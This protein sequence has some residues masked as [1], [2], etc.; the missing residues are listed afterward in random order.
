M[1][2]LWGERWSV[3]LARVFLLIVIAGF[4]AAHV[5]AEIIT[6][7]E[8]IFVPDAVRV[9]YC[10]K[11]VEFIDTAR[12]CEPSVGTAS[13][14]H[15]LYNQFFS[16]EFDETNKIKIRFTAG[17]NEVSVKVGLDRDYPYHTSDVFAKIDAYSSDTPGTGLVT[18]SSLNL[19]TTTTPI[20]KE[21]KVVSAAD[22]IRS[23]L[24]SFDDEGGFAYAYEVIDDLTFTPGGPSCGTE[25]T[26]PPTVQI[27]EPGTA[28]QAV[29]SPNMIL[30]F[31][32]KDQESGVAKIQ[33][34]FRDTSD[35]ELS[36][37]YTCGSSSSPPCSTPSNEVHYGF[38]TW[39]PSDLDPGNHPIII[40]VKAWD[41]AGNAGQAE[42]GIIHKQYGP[43]LN[44][45]VEA[46]E[47]TQG[48]QPWVAQ[49]PFSLSTGV[50]TFKY[51]AVP[52]A[53]PL[54]KGR[55]TVVRLYPS[56]EGTD[57][58]QL[59]NV[60]A[61]L[62]CY[63]DSSFSTPCPGPASISPTEI[64]LPNQL[65]KSLEAITLDPDFNLDT[66]RR[67]SVLSWNF[68]LPRPWTQLDEVYL[69][70]EVL[71]PAGLSECLDC[72]DGANAIRVSNV[73]FNQVPSFSNNLVHLVQINR[74]LNDTI[75]PPPTQQQIDNAVDILRRMF[76]IDET[77]VH[78][79]ANTSVLLEDDDTMDL[80]DRCS[81]PWSFLMDGIGNR[82]GKHAVYG[83]ID[84]DFPCAGVG[85]SGYAYGNAARPD[86]FPHEVGHAL[87][88]DHPGPEPGHG[89][90]CPRPD[91]QNCAECQNN[92][93][94]DDWPWPGGMIGAF[95]FDVFDYVVI[96]E[97]RLECKTP[98]VCENGINEDNDYWPG[99]S[100]WEMIDEECVGA[101]DSDPPADWQNDPHSFMS[102][103]GCT[104][105]IS[106]RNWIRIF[107]DFTKSSLPYPKSGYAS[108]GSA[109]V[110]PM[111]LEGQAAVVAVNNGIG[112]YLLVRGQ[113]IEPMPGTTWM[114]LPAYEIEL[115]LGT[116]DEVGEGAYQLQLLDSEGVVLTERHFNV[117]RRHADTLDLTTPLTSQP[118]FSEVLPLPE[119]V[120]R[121]VLRQ[122]DELLAETARSSAVPE[123]V[124]YS[125]TSGGFEGQP[126]NAVTRWLGSDA[127]GDDLYY[128]I[129]Y[130]SGFDQAG[131][132][133]WQTLALDWTDQQLPVL[134]GALAGSEE[135]M[136]RILAT[137]GFNTFT[138]S[139]SPFTVEGKAPR[140]KILTPD[141]GII[142]VSGQRVV[143][144][145]TGFDLEDGLLVSN[146]LSWSS[147]LNGPLGTGLQLDLCILTP[148]MHEITLEGT[149]SEGKTGSEAVYVT[150]NEPINSQPVADAGSDQMIAVGDVATL[151]G[152]AS[153]DLDGDPLMY[154]WAII[155]QPAGANPVFSNTETDQPTFAVDVTGDYKLE[156]VV[157]DGEVGSVPDTMEV[158]VRIDSDLDGV[159]DPVDNCPQKPNP[160]QDDLDEDGYGNACDTCT[161]T[162]Q[163][164][165]G[166]PD[167]PV[168]TCQQDNCPDIANSDQ[169]DVDGDGMGDIC[170]P[171]DNRPITG[172]VS[173]SPDLLWPP[174][175]KMIA[176][177][178]NPSNLVT[179][180]SDSYIRITAVA[181]LEY[182]KVSIDTLLSA[183]EGGGSTYEQN[184]FEPDWEITGDLTLNLRSERGGTFS[185]RTYRIT[186][187]ASDCSGDYDFFTEVRV[188]H[189][190]KK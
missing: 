85:G 136:V 110:A 70:G 170:D 41:Y 42:I 80:N 131:E 140:V 153:N 83:I 27:N 54:V 174:N 19:G 184:A 166:N 9:Q 115:S 71:P 148:G 50:P 175:H 2:G 139:S 32:A 103:G 91:G 8:S 87:G 21:L 114:F 60:K 20:N 135:A 158:Q 190:K 88:L 35:N 51:P 119:G 89:S 13:G 68:V 101:V 160:E 178:I 84:Q 113:F 138:V 14:T 181:V 47:I 173:A 147:N 146:A 92:W 16:S 106:P 18:S 95:G 100:N 130:S 122:G 141:D 48:T 63:T 5:Q 46:M 104:Q 72:D 159:P 179:H 188:P 132:R 52:T 69:E 12:I 59:D 133:V 94:E 15:A 61:L 25:D 128:M 167:F 111:A 164:G 57:G 108:A 30:D 10:G 67:V 143:A 118:S 121:I 183:D 151:N 98:G 171:C 26:Q 145:G 39:L 134:L 149:D 29:Y 28:G 150:V 180:N 102:Y 40:R 79:T 152:S 6:F 45:W 3:C 76:P 90:Y 4:G 36:S 156:L 155:S 127:D 144:L 56:I 112:R 44:L 74:R 65:A 53:V 105:W 116:A 109:E 58:S 161:D 49:N 33:V 177:S 182:G 123:V 62:N 154:H 24:I 165:Y 22:N 137:D 126:D 73:K 75:Q 66:K 169:S 120:T 163:D 86:S 38:S 172:T 17:Q 125:P 7:E 96:P 124:L 77:T 43:N 176:I 185:G 186:V 162:D 82:A 64:H 78:T 187:T 1:S 189:D 142:M 129:Q 99:G 11:G 117:G 157:N 37:F 23:V 168:N 31:T 55:T 34:L 93:C 107:N 81:M 97:D